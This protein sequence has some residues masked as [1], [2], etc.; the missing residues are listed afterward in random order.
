MSSIEKPEAERPAAEQ[1]EHAPEPSA[2]AVA[3]AG[4][5]ERVLKGRYRL[6]EEIARGG[7]GTVWLATDLVL[8]RQVA[9]KELRLPDDV[10][11]S[12]RESLLQRTTREARVAARLAHPGVVTVLDVVDEDERPWIVMEYIEASTLADI[13]QVAGPL[14][15]QRVAEIGLQLIDALKVAHDD[16]IVHR[17]VKPENVMISESGRVVLTDFGLAAWTGESALTSSGRIIGSPSYIP[18]ERAKAGPVGPESDLWSLGATLYAAV[19]GRP[20]YDRK[21]Y[22]RILK[23]V[24]LEEPP[25]AQNAGP[26]APVLAG[27]LHVQPG[28][29]L[30]ADNATKML[31]IAA[32]A[33]WAPETSPETAA[34]TAATGPQA[35]VPRPA[36]EGGHG[37]HEAPRGA[38]EAAAPRGGQ[39]GRTGA[40]AA[41]GDADE[42]DEEAEPSAA[43][44]ADDDT[45]DDDTPD[46][47]A[48]QAAADEPGSAGEHF[49]Q[50]AQML[51]A[52]FHESV[53][54][55]QDQ[56]SDSVVHL[57]DRFQRH[58]PEAVG[59]LLT[60]IRDSTDTLGLT[61]S[62]KH[63]GGG[64]VPVIIAV[65]VGVLL[66]LGVVLWGLL[67]R[68]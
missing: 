10:S 23:G 36:R 19:E 45:P 6:A 41:G 67:F 22:I 47:G 28:D 56:F 53:S 1:P 15:Y 11:A 65:A 21:G 27:L 37:A 64:S 43:G 2:P 35:V 57:H 48:A 68:T 5:A 40:P 14:P 51:R 60:S 12:E 9:V 52:S 26:L 39:Q 55:L 66:L 62:G 8:D 46:E 58:R 59:H 20:P 3:E 32:L 18:P 16:G 34:K 30:T 38:H 50:G 7:V 25:T 61:S 29:R 17:D 31:R 13:V 54:D 49:R 63:R 4:A 24:D 33:P 42:G 44:A